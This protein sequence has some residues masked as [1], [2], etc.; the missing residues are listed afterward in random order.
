[1]R[2]EPDLPGDADWLNEQFAD[3]LD[4]RVGHESLMMCPLCGDRRWADSVKAGTEEVACECGE[5]SMIELPQM[6]KAGD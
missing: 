5:S 6:R 3:A 2:W 1:M 4:M